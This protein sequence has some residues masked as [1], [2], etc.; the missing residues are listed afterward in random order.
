MAGERSCFFECKMMTH[1][2]RSCSMYYDAAMVQLH[3]GG[4]RST[5]SLQLVRLEREKRGQARASERCVK[6][7]NLKTHISFCARRSFF[8]QCTHSFI[9]F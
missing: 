2:H 8:I 1:H 4:K 7:A 5:Q 9:I 6:A 3:C